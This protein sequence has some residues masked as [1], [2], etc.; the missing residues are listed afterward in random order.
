MK[1]LITI[2]IL[3]AA[4]VISCLSVSAESIYRYGDWTFSAS[5]GAD[6][7]EFGVRSYEG[8]DAIVS[9]PGDYGGYPVTAINAYAFAANKT[10]REVTLHENTA[11]IGE[12]AFLAA[13]NLEKVTL[14]PS[15][16][17][18][19]K[20]AFAQCARLTEIE[21]PGIDTAIGDNAFQN[22][23]NAVIY[24]PSD[25][26]AIAYAKAHDVQYVCTD[27]Y[28]PGDANG[29]SR[30]NISDVTAIQRHIAELEIISGICLK[31]ADVNADSVVNITDATTIQMYLTEYQV[32]YP[33]GENAE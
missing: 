29:D 23:P 16:R 25:S 21:I 1:R 12:G 17:Q 33:V 22:S 7:Y 4:L 6:G 5:V 9:T 30:V 18:I 31:A 11:V 24:A 32:E 8:E 13:E 2:V 10:L 19:G 27:S 14:P 28:L 3:T 15:V 20:N 26:L